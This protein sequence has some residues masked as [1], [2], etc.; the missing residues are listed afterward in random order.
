MTFL[1]YVNNVYKNVKHV[2]I[3]HQIV[4]VVIQMDSL[5]IYKLEI[6]MIYTH[7]NLCAQINIMLIKI[8]YVKNVK[9]KNKFSYIMIIK[10]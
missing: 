2:V 9:I 1:V 4:L 8:I 5:N 6:K 3:H 10:I 7:V